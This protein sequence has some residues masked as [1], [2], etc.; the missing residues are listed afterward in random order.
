[1]KRISKILYG[2]LF[3]LALSVLAIP[4]STVLASE[5]TEIPELVEIYVQQDSASLEDERASNIILD[6]TINSSGRDWDQP[7]GYGYF[8]IWVEN[9]T[10]EEMNVIITYG[11][12]KSVSFDVPAND[13][14]PKTYSNA[15]PVHHDVSF[16]TPSGTITGNIKVRVSN[17]PLN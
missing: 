6:D 4:T 9:T 1:M 8:R 16:S 14:I 15:S 11:N 17:E 2:L 12:N 5:A 10:N 13:A 3:G 7:N